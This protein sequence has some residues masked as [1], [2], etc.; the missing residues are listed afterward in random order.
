MYQ[1]LDLKNMNLEEAVQLCKQE[2]AEE[3]KKTNMMPMMDGDL[4]E[5]LTGFVG[6][7]KKAP[8]GKVMVEDGKMIGFMASF[9][10]FDGFHGMTKGAFSPL[11]A[12][13]FAG[14]N[15]GKTASILVSAV[16]TERLK[17]GIFHMAMSRYANNEAVN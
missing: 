2:Y 12:S 13:A 17:D 1:L 7:A 3:F 6:I 14:Q 8:Y 15:R 5:Y 10:P 11:G 16:A 4:E 9:G